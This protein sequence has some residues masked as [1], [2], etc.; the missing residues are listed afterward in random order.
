MVR[1]SIDVTSKIRFCLFVLAALSEQGPKVAELVQA[2]S[3]PSLGEG[4][5]PPPFLAQ[6]QALGRLLQAALDRLVERD[7][8][9]VDENDRRAALLKARDGD[10]GKLRRRIVGLRR[11]I[12]GCYAAPEAAKLG[13][14]GRF[15][16]EP[17]ALLRQSELIC[18]RLQG[19]D[20]AQ[21]LGEPLFDPPIDPEPFARQVE[22]DIEVVRQSFDAHHR[23]KRRLDQLLAE[24]KTAMADYNVTFLRVARQFEDLCRLAGENDLADKVRPSASRP[25]QT[26]NDP[27]EDAVTPP[28]GDDVSEPEPAPADDAPEAELAA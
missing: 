12:F 3:L 26:E 22:P 11:I 21:T 18:K 17:I 2:K 4:D 13:L 20:L 19:D 15:S 24:K 23:S 9:L 8:E 27:A 1:L 25:G 28:A 7:R 5:E 16:R 6:I 10:A 14:V